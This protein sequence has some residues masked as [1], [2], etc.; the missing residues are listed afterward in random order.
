MAKKRGQAVTVWLP[1]DL[2]AQID[3]ENPNRSELV[4]QAL[5]SWFNRAPTDQEIALALD[6]VF[7]A[8]KARKGEEVQS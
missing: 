2:L 4:R 1:E 3:A 8:A 7:R 5:E 6:V